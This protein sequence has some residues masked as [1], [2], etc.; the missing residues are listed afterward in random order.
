MTAEEKKRLESFIQAFALGALDKDDFIEIVHFMQS[1]DEF[2]WQELGEYQNLT[3]LLISFINQK[4]VPPQSL[5]RILTKIDED[6]LSAASGSSEGKTLSF[7]KL[8]ALNDEKEES[9]QEVK[10]D[11]KTP[12][13][14]EEQDQ[15]QAGRNNQPRP[16]FNRQP[17]FQ[18]PSVNTQMVGRGDVPK[19]PQFGTPAED[20]RTGAPNGVPPKPQPGFMPHLTSEGIP[21]VLS[22]N[23][24]EEYPEPLQE[25]EV[26][27]SIEEPELDEDA[28]PLPINPRRAR[29]KMIIEQEAGNAENE[30]FGEN[31]EDTPPISTE[32]ESPFI[33]N[34]PQNS[35]KGQT[36]NVS[37][38]VTATSF[39][40]VTGTIVVCFSLVIFFLYSMVSD[41]DDRLENKLKDLNTAQAKTETLKN[42]VM[43]NQNLLLFIS[44]LKTV[45]IV[46]L[47]G[48]ED[49]P[50]AYGKFFYGIKE[51]RGFLQFSNIFSFN[52]GKGFQ[53][54]I[55]IN[56]K[57]VKVGGVNI[58]H[59]N[60]EFFEL[61]DVPDLSQTGTFK[62]KMTEENISGS[63]SPSTTVILSG[64]LIMKAQA[65]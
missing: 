4:E 38:S 33:E 40:A 52:A 64:L 24:E 12:D 61:I 54:W 47:L 49:Y 19:R 59:Q 23:F 35:H 55:S 34:F 53:L 2:A 48:T 3:A 39:W 56:D 18:R 37:G 50:D 31:D 1:N 16:S 22:E 63:D 25:S 26:Q 51:K 6:G 20:P 15:F 13:V 42:T 21:E 7:T 36:I 43:M 17:G 65:N 5:D 8:T 58:P 46:N 11:P 41:S 10:R 44:T 28:P 32:N 30:F 29:R 57:Y 27:F 45:G 14:Q 9:N 60:I 62:V